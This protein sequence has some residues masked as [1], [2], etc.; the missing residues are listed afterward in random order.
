MFECK[1]CGKNLINLSGLNQHIKKCEKL[2]LIKDEIV[3]LYVNEH[4]S[5]THLRKKFKIQSTDIKEVLGDKIRTISEA[6]KLS[7]I[8][9]PEKYRHTDETKKKLRDLR[10][11]FM[12]NN[13]EKTSWRLSNISYPEKL[14]VDYIEKNELNK[15]YSIIREYSVF[16]YFIDFA[17]INEMVA[18]EIDGS[19][20]LL[21]DRKNNDD[22]KDKLLNDLGWVVIRISE[23]EIKTDINQVFNQIKNIL[24]DK[25][26]INNYKI[27]LIVKPKKYQKKERNEFGF[28]ESQIIYMKQQR[29]VERPPLNELLK[30]IEENGF[31]KTGKI[32][33]VSD[34]SIRKWV[35]AYLKGLD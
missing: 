18:I 2:S 28:T 8:K 3:D 23:K 34:N 5:V 13:P 32:F 19:Q 12:K 10:L 4:Y 33:G 26:K 17:F 14:F 35:K 21:P 31:V 29:K 27:G 9:F 30:V 24:N 20:H 15:N 16:P 25:P 7:R 6:N 22:K 1:F 11:N